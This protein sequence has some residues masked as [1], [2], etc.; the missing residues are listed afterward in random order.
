VAKRLRRAK[1]EPQGDGAREGHAGP[2]WTR[3]AAKGEASGPSGLRSAGGSRGRLLTPDNGNGH[4]ADALGDGSRLPAPT[5]TDCRDHAL[6]SPKAMTPWGIV[7]LAF[8]EI[9]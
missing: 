3:G 9:S 8:G 7:R 2:K 5:T 1:S 6:K 4:C